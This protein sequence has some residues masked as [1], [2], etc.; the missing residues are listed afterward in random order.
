MDPAMLALIKQSIGQYGQNMPGLFYGLF[1]NAGEPYEAAGE[2]IDKYYPQAQQYQNPFYQAGAGAIPQ[3]QDWLKTMQNPTDF[4]NKTM[5]QYQESPYAHY[6]QQQAIRAGENAGSASGLT[7]S[8]PLT[9]FMQQNAQDISSKDM[10]QWLQ[11]VLGVNTQYGQGVNNL[12]TGGQNAAN[13][14]TNLASDY[15]TNK[16]TLAYGQS[17]AEQ[18]QKYALFQSL[19]KLLFGF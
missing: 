4:I 2:A 19:A 15:M 1:G 5:N 12:M 11:N 8:T 17:Q 16:G 9:Q 3:Y 6:Q 14:L 13:A 10:N 7:G 18:G